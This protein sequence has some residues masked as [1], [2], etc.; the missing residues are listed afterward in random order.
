MLSSCF[1][2]ILALSV[3]LTTD[4]I[5][6]QTAFKYVFIPLLLV[7]V[8]AVAVILIRV[9]LPH[10]FANG[11]AAIKAIAAGTGIRRWTDNDTLDKVLEDTGFTYDPEQDIFYSIINAWQQKFGYCQLYDEAAAPM[12][13]I[14][15]CEP[16]YFD[17]GGKKWLIELWKGQYGMTTGGEIGVFTTEG[18]DL[19]IPHVFN[20]TYYNNAA[21]EDQLQ[22]SF[23]LKK[24]QKIIFA[25]DD[26]QW[27]LTGFKLGEFSEPSE[28]TMYADITL[29]DNLMC[30]AFVK[31]L[32]NAGYTDNELMIK[33]NTVSLK[34]HYAHTPQPITRTTPTDWIIQRKNE[35]LCAEYR[36]ITNE[37]DN[38]PDKIKAIHKQSPE[39]IGE[40][41]NIRR[42]KHLTEINQ[43]IKNYINE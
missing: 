41:K 31:G 3:G 38:M 9:F 13:M 32:K 42:T 16:I 18:S 7:C 39:L 5:A 2:G 23:S 33:G 20:G 8:L 37:Y 11:I 6:R 17:Y 12:G 43:S 15:D 40:I 19:N 26:L 22:L 10:W 29:K 21:P 35:R 27:W 34:F 28:L 25:R 24:N 36:N 30:D 4:E 14:I 1:N